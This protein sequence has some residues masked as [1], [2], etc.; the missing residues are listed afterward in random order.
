VGEAFVELGRVGV[1]DHPVERRLSGQQRGVVLVPQDLA[2]GGRVD[3]GAVVDAAL[4][5]PHD[6]VHAGHVHEQVDRAAG[7]VDQLGP[8]SQRL[9]VDRERDLI[10]GVEQRPHHRD[11]P[12]VHLVRERLVVRGAVGGRRG[13]VVVDVGPQRVEPLQALERGG[14][15]SSH[16]GTGRLDLALEAVQGLVG[17]RP[18]LGVALD[19]RGDA[20]GVP[21]GQIDRGPG[22]LALQPGDH[23]T[24]TDRG[25]GQLGLLADLVG[26]LCGRAD[27]DPHHR[28]QGQQGHG[29]CRREL[30]ADGDA[31]H[32]LRPPGGA[33]DGG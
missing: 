8:V 15:G 28:H 12:V 26:A 7:H 23:A 17:G 20:E 21:P 33:H 2:R 1:R 31:T 10:G 6:E 9:V 16:C 14:E 11:V 19:R 24:G 13:D 5:R 30:Q 22:A 25:T 3:L 29:Q 18:G 32:D 4:P 27:F